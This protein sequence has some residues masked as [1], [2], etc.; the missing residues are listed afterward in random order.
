MK[1]ISEQLAE[2]PPEL[3]EELKSQQEE[4]WNE[5]F[6]FVTDQFKCANEIYETQKNFP[7]MLLLK[8]FYSMGFYHGIN[9]ILDPDEPY[10]SEES[11]KFKNG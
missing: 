4:R 8:A 11:M 9:F 1:N 2:F 7:I 5:T 3:L 10:D 6:L